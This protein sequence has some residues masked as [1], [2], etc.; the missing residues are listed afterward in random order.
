[1]GWNGMDE[2]DE[3]VEKNLIFLCGHDVCTLGLRACVPWDYSTEQTAAGPSSASAAAYRGSLTSVI[4]FNFFF[5]SKIIIIRIL[6]FKRQKSNSRQDH[7]CAIH[8]DI[9]RYD[10]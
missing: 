6:L 8:E 2:G 10:F 5:F 1:M 4:F 9:L 7:H 3:R